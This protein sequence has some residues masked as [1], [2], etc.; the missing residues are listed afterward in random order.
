MIVLISSQSCLAHSCIVVFGL[1]FA[2]IVAVLQNARVIENAEGLRTTPS[3][4]AFTDKGERLVGT[5]AK[6]QVCENEWSV[7]MG[8]KD[9]AA[10]LLTFCRLASLSCWQQVAAV[11]VLWFAQGVALAWHPKKRRG[12]I[13][14]MQPATR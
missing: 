9:S 6:R 8:G 14:G 10:L 7:E 3:V 12:E 11:A 5:P 13:W 1:L 4:V 2:V